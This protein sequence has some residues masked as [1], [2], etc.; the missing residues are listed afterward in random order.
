MDHDD[1]IAKFIEEDPIRPGPA[2]VRLKDYGVHVWALIGHLPMAKNGA[3]GVAE[4]YNVPLEA[5]QAA[6][7]YYDRHRC[8]IDGR[9]AANGEPVL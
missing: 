5:V 2:D 1:L 8:V 9:L 4:D 6:L 3:E 7:A